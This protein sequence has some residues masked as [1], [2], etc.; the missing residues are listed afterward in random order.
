MCICYLHR[1]HPPTPFPPSPP[2]HRWGDLKK[3]EFSSW[4]WWHKPVI[5]ELW[6]LRQEDCEFEVILGYIVRPV[7]KNNKKL[8][9]KALNAV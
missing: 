6:R 2:S 9:K 5:P 1:I 3:K 8:N 4:A 7:S